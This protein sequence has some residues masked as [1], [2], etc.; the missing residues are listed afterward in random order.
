MRK[1][2]YLLLIFIFIGCSTISVHNSFVESISNQD[3]ITI[4]SLNMMGYDPNNSRIDRMQPVIDLCK[5]DNVDILLLQEG[6]SG[7]FQ[8]DSINYLRDELGFP[9]SFEAPVFGVYPFSLQNIGIISRYPWLETDSSPCEIQM[10]ETIDN[11]PVPNKRRVVMGQIDVPG[12]GKINTYSVHMASSPTTEEERTKQISCIINFID[13]KT[14]DSAEILGGDFN[15]SPDS[16]AYKV[17]IDAGFRGYGQT[18]DFIFVR[19]PIEIVDWKLVF[20]DHF[21]SDHCGILVK[22]Q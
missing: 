22:I 4:L 16:P 7:L 17:I 2:I 3:Q 6:Y 9:A 20:A 5:Q 14:N 13:S 18:P 8:R 19:G 21:V 1:T 10:I 12:M 11:L 15:M